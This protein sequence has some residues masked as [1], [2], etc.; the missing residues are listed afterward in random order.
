MFQLPELTNLKKLQNKI[1]KAI[2]G[3]ICVTA[4]TATHTMQGGLLL[5]IQ[6]CVQVPTWS[7]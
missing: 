4:A 7:Q 2:T 1:I 3:C 6:E 5:D